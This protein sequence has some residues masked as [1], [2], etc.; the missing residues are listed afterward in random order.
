TLH[1][2]EGIRSNNGTPD[3]TWD[4]LRKDVNFVPPIPPFAFQLS[5]K[6]AFTITP[7][8]LRHLRRYEVQIERNNLIS[9]MSPSLIQSNKIKQGIYEA[10]A[11]WMLNHE[12]SFS[13]LLEQAFGDAVGAAF[14]PNHYRYRQIPCQ[15]TYR[16]SQPALKSFTP[17]SSSM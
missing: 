12:I 2:K 14:N 13:T 15:L 16:I 5:F 4:E 6:S 8:N 10:F 3:V 1:L 17:I 9:L 11:D 7:S